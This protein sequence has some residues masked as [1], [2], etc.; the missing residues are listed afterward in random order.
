MTAWRLDPLG[1]AAM[2]ATLESAPDLDARARNA[3]ALALAHYFERCAGE[4]RCEDGIESIVPALDSVLIAFDPLRLP[5]AK[6]EAL[7]RQ[8]T[9]LPVTDVA[10]RV[11]ALPVRFGGADGPDLPD[12]AGALGLPPEEVVRQLCGSEWPVLMIGFAP[13]FPYLGP[14]P[15]SLRLPRRS[16]P[17]LAVPLGSVAI[18]AGM[19][20]IYP[21]RLPGGWHL[22]GRTDAILFDPQR[23]PPALLRAGDR[24]RFIPQ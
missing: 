13:G 24:V 14:L 10:G 22:V 16:T 9:A 7:L 4:A 8:A 11:A 23:D 1:E 5:R 12:V 20:G 3:A 15:E 21:A 19:A 6:V 17:R 2:L 18:A